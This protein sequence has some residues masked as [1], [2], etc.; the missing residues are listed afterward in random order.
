MEDSGRQPR[1]A[2][3]QPPSQQRR[4]TAFGR[5]GIPPSSRPRG[6]ASRAPLQ[7]PLPL[8]QSPG[9]RQPS[10]GRGS[11]WQHGQT[12]TPPRQLSLRERVD[13]ALG[14]RHQPL[15]TASQ[16]GYP[17]FQSQEPSQ[18]VPDSQL[19]YGS[20]QSADMYSSQR[21][22]DRLQLAASQPWQTSLR[23][24]LTPPRLRL[25]QTQA[26]QH[27]LPP[28]QPAEPHA[29]AP[30]T[31]D[32]GTQCDPQ[33]PTVLPIDPALLQQIDELAAS[34]A[35]V[36]ADLA[37]LAQSS[38]AQQARLISLQSTCTLVL[39]AVQVRLFGLPACV[40]LTRAEGCS[41]VQ[42]LMHK[43]QA[44]PERQI[45]HECAVQT[46]ALPQALLAAAGVQTSLALQQ[47]AAVP[48][49]L[50]ASAQADSLPRP[51]PAAA[52]QPA[53]QAT[54]TSRLPSPH[55]SAQHSYTAKPRPAP[56]VLPGQSRCSAS[57]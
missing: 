53:V 45:V 14:T 57:L 18:P 5:Q 32:T 54:Q 36:K 41:A 4:P 37:S 24:E 52:A 43:Q 3:P 9:L 6:L 46:S 38:S 31:A 50:P 22:E 15:Q 40:H 12:G 20:L 27:M 25:T 42:A 26:S 1:G 2:W 51:Q 47:A 28:S 34:T 30:V 10:P 7:S 21:A 11:S 23:S 29:L 56:D 33:P 8:S 13:A 19:P 48:Q 55:Q 17:A 16:P 35:D 44:E 39:K 49:S